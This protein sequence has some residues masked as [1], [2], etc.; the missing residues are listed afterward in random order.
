MRIWVKSVNMNLIANE[1]PF[2]KPEFSNWENELHLPV[3][4]TDSAFKYDLISLFH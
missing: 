1:C 3:C 2:D 4:I